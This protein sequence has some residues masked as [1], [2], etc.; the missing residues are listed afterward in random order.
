M[1]AAASK[2]ICVTPPRPPIYIAEYI[3]REKP[4]DKWIIYSHGTWE[5]LDM[6]KET[7]DRLGSS[8]GCNLIAYEY[9]GFG[10]LS[11]QKPSEEKMVSALLACHK[12]VV[13]MGV[14]HDKII[15]MGF[16]LGA[17]VT[18]LGASRLRD[19]FE[20]VISVAGFA[21]FIRLALPIDVNFG[22]YNVLRCIS[23]IDRPIHFVHGS[24][25]N[26]V[27]YKHSINMWAHAKELGKDAELHLIPGGGHNVLGLSYFLFVMRDVIHG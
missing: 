7:C 18:L 6:I 27:K 21:S 15:L 23:S 1:G 20:A 17:V 5:H 13:D 8:L 12:K 4:T 14:P 3:H 24:Y 22:P 2:L 10:S 19:K 16:S 11:N 25:D 9:P 26:Y